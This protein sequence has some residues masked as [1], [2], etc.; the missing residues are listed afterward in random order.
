MVT[1]DVSIFVGDCLDILPHVPDGCVDLAF[2]DLPYGTTRNA[3][4]TPID[5]VRLWRELERIGRPTTPYVFTAAQPFTTDLVQSN[6]AAFRFSMVWEKSSP[7][8]FLN[9]KK[10]PLR[11]HE[12]V[13][14]FYRRPPAYAAQVETGHTPTAA[15]HGGTSTT[16]YDK[17]GRVRVREIAPTER[18]PRSILRVP[19]P[20]ARGD[21]RINATQ[22]PDALAA[23]FIRTYTKPGDLV[24]DPTCGSGST[25]RAAKAEG[26]RW[27]GI[28]LD[29]VQAERAAATLRDGPPLTP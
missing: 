16:N 8:G 6:R 14:V 12:D 5:L 20:R 21:A 9:A 26:R 1:E 25:L 13:L 27:L 15:D 11:S 4:D 23:W 22:K 3:W 2:L 17:V 7:S 18:Y 24:L 29:P 19:S 28:E 10:Q